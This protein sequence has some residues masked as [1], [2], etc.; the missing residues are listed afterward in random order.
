[1]VWAY[2]EDGGTAMAK[3]GFKMDPFQPQKVQ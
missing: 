3:E 2:Q 1:M